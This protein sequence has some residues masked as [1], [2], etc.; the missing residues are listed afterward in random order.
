MGTVEQW[1]IQMPECSAVNLYVSSS[2]GG[3]VRIG[4]SGAS[5]PAWKSIECPIEPSLT[6]VMS[7][8]SPTFPRSVGPGMLS[9]KVHSFCSTPGATSCASSATFNVT[10]RSEEHTSE[11]QSRGH[12][13]CRLLLDKKNILA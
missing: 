9:P 3:I 8:V 4:S 6:S 10:S 1:Y 2:P 5:I 13:V 7:K 12:I 11:L